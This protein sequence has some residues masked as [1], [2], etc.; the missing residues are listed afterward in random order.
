L[1]PEE[2]RRAVLATI[3]AI[4]PETDLPGIRPDQPLRAQVEL[5]SMDWLNVLIGLRDRLGIEIREAD[6]GRLTTLDAIV[7]FVAAGHAGPAAA[8]ARAQGAEAAALATT[9]HRIDGTELTVRPIRADD[10]PLEADFVRH[11]SSESRYE[12][13]MVTVGELS[14]RKLEYLTDVDQL[15]HVALVATTAQDGRETIVGVVRYIV[16]PAGTGCEFAVAIDDAWHG[17]G[18]AGILMQ[19]L[20]DIAR[21]RGLRTMEGFVL[22]ANAPMLRFARQLGFRVRRDPEDRDTVH[23]ERSL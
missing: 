13:F 23:V 4:A 11:L 20:I 8:P 14:A 2:I 21:A 3:G 18:L 5:D 10:L 17:T 22:A 9:R 19:A 12:R 15:R 1:E 16:D 7:A 6:Y